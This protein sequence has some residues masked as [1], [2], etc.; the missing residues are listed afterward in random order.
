[1]SDRKDSHLSSDSLYQQQLRTLASVQDFHRPPS[2]RFLNAF[3]GSLSDSKGDTNRVLPHSDLFYV[4]AA[5]EARFP[6]RLFTMDEIRALI[7]EIYGV[8]Y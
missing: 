8:E 4:R 5:L 6:D 7:L 2:E 3:Y 1:M